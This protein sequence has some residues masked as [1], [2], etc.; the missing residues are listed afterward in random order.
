M[1]ESIRIL[2]VEDNPGD[3]R[4]LREFLADVENTPFDPVHVERLGN[5]LQRLRNERFDVILLDL[6]LP[7]AQGLET[8]TRAY[9]QGAPIVV[10]TG[11]DDK[12]LAINALREGAQDYLVKGQI[13][14]PLLERSIR[15]AIE[16]HRAEEMIEHY[17]YYDRL[18]DLPNRN[19]LYDR[20]QQAV[21]AARR[22]NKLVA[23]L[24][25]DLDRFKEINDALGHQFGDR[26]LHQI[27]PR[28]QVILRASDTIARLGGDEFAV[29]LPSVAS[30]EAAREVARKILKAL[31][32]PFVIGGLNIDIEASIG[33]AVF[34]EHGDDAG[35][36]FKRAD[37][38]MYIAKETQSG[39]ALYS[40]E[41]DDNSSHRVT[42]MA[43]LRRAILEDELFLLYKPKV[44]L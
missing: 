5:A 8:I 20:L 44:D 11:L 19:L 26:L 3:A 6:S 17:A 40:A 15:Y 32:N 30:T 2:L 23:L 35:T 18:T 24:I 13:E 38:A 27:G 21:L 33:I 43:D 31:E 12:A 29:L 39:Y 1:S 7:D 4:L 36:L 41:H 16:R 42:L 22:E 10:L 28:L 14:A 37:V 9:K 34:P 25:L